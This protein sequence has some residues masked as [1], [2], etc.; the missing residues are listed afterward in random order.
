MG[1]ETIDINTGYG[2][3]PVPRWL[4]AMWN[5]NGW[6]AEHVLKRMGEAGSVEA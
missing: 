5:Q 1:D 6:P 4:L 2:M 3:V